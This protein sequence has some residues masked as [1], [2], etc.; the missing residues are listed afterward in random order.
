MSSE[1]RQWSDP[2]RLESKLRGCLFLKGTR[3][4]RKSFEQRKTRV[5]FMLEEALSG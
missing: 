3:E 5:R 1:M 4:P 2:R